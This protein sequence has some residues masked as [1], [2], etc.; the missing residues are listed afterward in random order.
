MRKRCENRSGV[1]K[2]VRESYA[3]KGATT[4]MKAVTEEQRTD[5]I[6]QAMSTGYT[7]SFL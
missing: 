4:G 7:S 6:H 3:K 5:F 2:K 1:R